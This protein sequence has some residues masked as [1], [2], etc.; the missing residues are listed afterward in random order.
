MKMVLV[1]QSLIFDKA[2]LSMAGSIGGLLLLVKGYFASCCIEK[3][4]PAMRLGKEGGSAAALFEKSAY[5]LVESPGKR[6]FLSTI[7]TDLSC[8]PFFQ[9]AL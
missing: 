4:G 1:C 5:L 3:Q 8:T 9:N 6:A 2:L 7:Q